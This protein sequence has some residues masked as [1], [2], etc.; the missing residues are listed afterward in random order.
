VE[1]AP[2]VERLVG[3][4]AEYGIEAEPPSPV[5]KQHGRDDHLGGASDSGKEAGSQKL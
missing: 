5:G 2:G 3:V 4:G 1:Q